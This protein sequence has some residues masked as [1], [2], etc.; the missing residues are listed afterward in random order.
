MYTWYEFKPVEQ[1]L[2]ANTTYA[3]VLQAKYGNASNYVEWA[4]YN[5]G[6]YAGGNAG[7]SSNGG[8]DWT[9]NCTLD[10]LFQIWGNP[11]M[12]VEG[13]K[14]FSSYQEPGD[15]LITLLYKNTY[16]PYYTQGNDVSN[17]FYVQLYNVAGTTLLAQ[18]KCPMW[19]YRPA[20]IY[21]SAGQVT[22]LQ[23]GAAYRVRIY[24]NFYPYP[25]MEYILQPEDWLGDDLNRL[26]SWVKGTTSL[27]ETY[28]GL[29]LTTFIASKGLVLNET[30]GAIFDTCIPTLSSVRPDIFQIV[31]V[32]P[33]YIDIPFTG[34]TAPVWTTMLGPQVT[35]IFN[36]FGN[37]FN[38]SGGTF[39][40]FIGFAF[41]AI[42][43]A[44]CFPPGSAIAA[45]SVPFVILLA[46]WVTVTI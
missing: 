13:A 21:L 37:T 1:C 41:Y 23:W 18:T 44:L 4:G 43:A 7:Y 32:T 45:I 24:G 11:C 3:I 31:T 17:F 19:G 29:T 9:A 34:G 27:M 30:G 38:I 42:V 39:G 28:Y 15:W 2:T 46:V 8:S 6:T 10:Q 5:P 25:H 33:G 14:V 36:D 22:S 12:N 35:A 16:E 26:D 40:A 20:N